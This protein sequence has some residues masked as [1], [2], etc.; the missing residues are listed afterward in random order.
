MKRSSVVTFAL[1]PATVA[2]LLAPAPPRSA[3]DEVHR[4]T[5]WSWTGPSSWDAV[6]SKQGI[7]IS[8]PDGRRGIDWGFS[9]IFC[10]PREQV[11]GSRRRDSSPAKAPEHQ[12]TSL[13]AQGRLQPGWPA[14]LPP[15]LHRHGGQGRNAGK[16]PAGLRLR[17]RRRQHR[18]PYCYQS[19]SSSW[20]RVAT[21]GAA[22]GS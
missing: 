13:R 4:C 14:L 11:A 8:S 7:S 22:S 20:F 15:D 16:G 10:V 2:A 17:R 19:P 5:N 3:R 1:C 12:R 18:H 9:N 6:C 21:T